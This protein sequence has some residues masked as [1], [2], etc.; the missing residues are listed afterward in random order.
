MTNRY[1]D[2]VDFEKRFVVNLSLV[3]VLF[4]TL[5]F[6]IN[7]LLEFDLIL[8]ILPVVSF[9]IYGSLYFWARQSKKA[10]GVKWVFALV[11]L[12]FINLLWVNN[13][14]SRGPA[15]YFFILLYSLLIF[16]WHGKYL[17]IASS[18]LIINVVVIFFFDLANP[19]FT[20][21][22]ASE[23]DRI[24]DVYT[25]IM[26]Y[27]LVIFVMMNGAK[28]SYV[29]EY[30]KAKRSDA[31]K[32]AF[33]ANMSHEIRTPLNAIVGFSNL[34]SSNLVPEEE[35]QNYI[36][37]INENNDS[38]LRLFEDIIDISS[39]DTG[40]LE[41]Y[42]EDCN[43]N[44]LLDNLETTYNHVLERAEKTTITIIKTRLP[45]DMVI[46]TDK[47]RLLQILTNLMDNAVKFTSEGSISMGCERSG[48]GLTFYVK[49]TGI[50]IPENNVQFIFDRFYKANDD[51]STLY[52]GT[53]IGLFMAKSLAE[54]L[55]G[56]IRMES[57][58]G[59]GS[60]FYLN[61]PYN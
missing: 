46:S 31:L 16:V 37:I 53:G 22:Y 17:I 32:S 56:S 35:K 24:I 15:P 43:I 2:F 10:T 9:F 20:P 12:I 23:S 19:F 44:N 58:E 13:Y 39:I 6:I 54:L 59:K 45:E 61:I 21:G 42:V 41:L 4:S 47:K 11:T 51:Q 60:A 33:L 3:S 5:G 30:K 49:D 38:L 57:E 40:Q 36:E 14:G 1:E 29:N 27:A 25:G 18:I 28:K 34:L 8:K 55:G 50:G 52:R 26:L 48:E 7:S